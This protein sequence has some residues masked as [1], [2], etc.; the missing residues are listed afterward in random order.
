LHLVARYVDA[1]GAPEKV[2]QTWHQ[3]P[4]EN[5]LVL[6][7]AEWA[8]LLPNGPHELDE[9]WTLPPEL[10]RQILLRFYPTTQ[11]GRPA[12][13]RRNQVEQVS[14]RGRIVARRE[15]VRARLEG[16]I[17]MR[18]SFYPIVSPDPPTLLTASVSGYLE[19]EPGGR[20]LSLKLTTDQAKYG[21]F[22]FAV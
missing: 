10:A 22:P 17:R 16:M 18:R 1:A 21:T 13:V 3:M 15:T 12:R 8:R 9:P 11:G 19:F 20:I 5:W 2:R 14:L 4:A 7:R 6:P